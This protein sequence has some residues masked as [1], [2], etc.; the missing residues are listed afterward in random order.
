MEMEN[1][2]ESENENDFYELHES[3]EQPIFLIAQAGRLVNHFSF[4]G[5]SWY[6]FFNSSANSFSTE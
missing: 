1:E 6:G 3:A 4:S 2:K 5:C